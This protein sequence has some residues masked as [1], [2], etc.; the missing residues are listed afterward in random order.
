[1]TI[2]DFIDSQS[3][4]FFCWGFVGAMIGSIYT[5]MDAL[6]DEYKKKPTLFSDI[7]WTIVFWH[8][9]GFL[10]SSLMGGLFAIVIDKDIRFAIIVGTFV[11][12]VYINLYKRIK[13]GTTK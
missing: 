12:L 5:T 10:A 3:L 11:D 2:F 13:S 1:M 8:F 4:V 6:L 9:I 7:N